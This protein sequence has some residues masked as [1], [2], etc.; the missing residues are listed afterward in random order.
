MSQLLIEPVSFNTWINFFPQK[1][2]FLEHLFISDF[3][4]NYKCIQTQSVLAVIYFLSH[5]LFVLLH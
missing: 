5:S 2:I 3:Y 4:L 1:E